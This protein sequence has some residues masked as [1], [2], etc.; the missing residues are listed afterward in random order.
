MKIK[1]ISNNSQIVTTDLLICACGYEERCIHWVS[2]VDLNLFE[3]KIA[4][5]FPDEGDGSK[6]T[7]DANKAF[8]EKNGFTLIILNPEI[9]IPQILYDHLDADKPEVRIVVDYSSMTR[10]W[11]ADII[12]AFTRINNESCRISLQFVYSVYT[13]T[14][15]GEME[16]VKVIYPMPGYGKLTIPDKPTA[17]IVGIGAEKGL[18][19]YIKEFFDADCIHYF[20]TDSAYSP[21]IEETHRDQLMMEPVENCHQYSLKDGIMLIKQLSEVCRALYKNY[22]VIILPC[23]PKPFTLYSLLLST[24]IP[25][26]E[27]WCLRMQKHTVNKI[28]ENGSDYFYCEVIFGSSQLQE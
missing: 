4:L 17:L 22:R 1:S 11:Y 25:D 10:F 28:T 5:C 19:L 20:Y 26:I 27:V 13:L 16:G 9:G 12:K 6:D 23:G 24:I 8:Y 18:P 15:S 21:S 3:K 14:E 2:S 7:Y